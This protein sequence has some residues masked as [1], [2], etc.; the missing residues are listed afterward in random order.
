MRLDKYL[1]KC[2]LGTRTMV[3]KI[4]KDK[5]I[6]VND[7]IITK[8]DYDVKENFDKVFYQDQILKYQEYYYFMLNKPSGYITSTSDPLN[9]TVMEL[10]NNLPPIL[11]QNLFPIGRL[12]KDTTGLLI[13][14]NDGAFAHFLTSPN[15]HVSKTYV[16]TYENTLV[17]NAVSLVENGLK[18][19]T[20]T[21]RPASIKIIDD[22]HCYLTIE[23][24]KYHQIKKMIHILG[25]VLTSLKRIKIGKLT[26]PAD[27]KEGSFKEI[28]KEDI[29]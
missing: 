3:K 28:K 27:L 26:L 8:E 22:N 12:D 14:T 13:I 9:Q 24:G 16:V 19:D 5:L 4:I 18:D 25:G 7:Q 17:S 20:N 1:T 11:V 15:H 2:Y 10:F 21:F 6:K 29:I 23:E